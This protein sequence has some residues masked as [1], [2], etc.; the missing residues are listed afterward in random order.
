M[1]CF[2][3][4]SH[5]L[6]V[7]TVHHLEVEHT[8][9]T[10]K[11]C[12]RPYVGHVTAAHMRLDTLDKLIALERLRHVVIGTSAQRLHGQGS[13]PGRMEKGQVLAGLQ[14]T[15]TSKGRVA[16]QRSG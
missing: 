11:R 10:S 3:Y 12:K 14:R 7:H 15:G 4:P 5:L 9:T 1:Q 8:A 16:G 2:S 13:K 6:P